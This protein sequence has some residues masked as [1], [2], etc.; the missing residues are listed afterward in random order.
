MR[1][2]QR[3]SFL[4]VLF[5]FLSPVLRNNAFGAIYCVA[6]NGNDANSGSIASPFATLDKAAEKLKP[7]DTLLIRGGTYNQTMYCSSSGT[8]A[9]PITIA[10][11]PGERAIIDGAYTKP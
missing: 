2:L 10:S 3:L 9:L 11:Y 7:G 4:G 5:C 8:P 6:T 1:L